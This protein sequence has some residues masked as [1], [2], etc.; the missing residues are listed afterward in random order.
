MKTL[1]YPRE[2]GFVLIV[3]M[4]VLL[5]LTILVV[6]SV[7]SSVLGEKMAGNYMDRNRALQAAEQALRQGEAALLGADSGQTCL[8]GCSITAGAVAASTASVNAIP[9][10][11]SDPG[12]ATI[13]TAY[14]QLTTAKYQVN[15]LND[16]LRA[17]DKNDCKAYSVMGRGAG[18]DSRAVVLLQTVV[19]VC[20]IA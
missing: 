10:A 17:A 6:N 1:H 15:Q 11:W 13:T 8:S 4:L 19:Y 14:G 20:P 18:V 3:S 5:I 7:R 12:S 16:S 2:K 9:S